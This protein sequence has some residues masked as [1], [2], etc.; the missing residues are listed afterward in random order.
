[1][2]HYYYI[3]GG[4]SLD[5]QTDSELDSWLAALDNLQTWAAMKA[6]YNNMPRAAFIA[7][8]TVD[9]R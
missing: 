3:H 6:Q 2:N 8:F 5:L 4:E 7:L 9:C 1:M